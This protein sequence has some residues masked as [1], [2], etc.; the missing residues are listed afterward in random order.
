MSLSP[1]VQ[2]IRSI[3][4]TIYRFYLYVQ[5]GTRFAVEQLQQQALNFF[6]RCCLKH[7]TSILKYKATHRTAKD[8]MLQSVIRTRRMQ[9]QLSHGGHHHHHHREREN[10]GQRSLA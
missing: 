3:I 1:S 2:T 5:N 10:Q 4:H 6:K 9:Q 7:L 8:T